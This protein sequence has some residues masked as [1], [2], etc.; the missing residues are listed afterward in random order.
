MLRRLAFALLV[1]LASLAP[2]CSTTRAHVAAFLSSK[3]VARGVRNE[4]DPAR[5]AWARA[6]RLRRG[7]NLSHWFSQSPG[8]DYSETHLRTHT[9][10]RDIALIKEMG[11]DHVRFP[12]EPAPLFDEEHPSDLNPEY[13]RRLDDALDMLLA[14][15]LSVVFDLHPSDEFKIRL[16]TDDRHVEA[17]AEFWRAL[18]RHLARRDPERLFLEIINEPMVEDAYRWMGI[19]ARVAAT[20]RDGAPRHTIIATGPRWSSVDELLRIEPLADQN[21]IYNFHLYEP[22]TFT[23]Q[24]AT[25]GA[26]YWPYIKRVP[27]PSS[28]EAVAPLLTSVEHESA[29]GALRA[30]GEERWNAER[31]ERMVALAADWAQRRGVPLTCNEFGVYR[32][33]SPV[34]ARLRWIEDVRTALERHRIGW[35]IWD[36]ADSFGVAVKREGRA[37]PDPQT[38]AALGL[39]AQK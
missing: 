39:Q 3:T 33:Y 31:I 10:A 28:P 7:V 15:G 22:H 4:E 23:H 32:T 17:F 24:C 18:A 14:S 16:R 9:T 12:I 25:W 30:Y 11:F 1:A 21:V 35:A 26:E 34:P 38:V 6:A 13:L 36:Y 29:R 27:Y 19:Q 8:R 5:V 2:P 37:T 20:I